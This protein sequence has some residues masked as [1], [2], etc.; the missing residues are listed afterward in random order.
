[1]RA[2]RGHPR[3]AVTIVAAVIVLALAGVGGGRALGGAHPVRTN[4]A[5][6]RLVASEATET[7]Q[8]LRAAQTQSAGLRGQ[9]ATLTAQLR[10]TPNCMGARAHQAPEANALISIVHHHRRHSCS[11]T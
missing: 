9:P 8:Q 1:M 6:R 3:I 5:A 11:E 7:R 2:A 4:H 10:S